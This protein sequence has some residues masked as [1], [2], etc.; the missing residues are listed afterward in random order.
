MV[1]KKKGFLLF[2]LAVVL[3]IIFLLAGFGFA[4]SGV[5]RRMAVR[6]DVFKIAAILRYEW[7]R[8]CACQKQ[9]TVSIDLKKN[10]LRDEQH[11]Y[12]LSSDVVFGVLAS[13]HGP[14][15]RPVH[16]LTTPSSFPDNKI[17]FFP[18]RDGHCWSSL[19]SRLQS[20]NPVCNND[21]ASQYILCTCL[22]I[23]CK[24]MDFGIRSY[25]LD[26]LMV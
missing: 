19:Y 1:A 8:A 12:S 18:R 2:E 20:F 10:C 15:S 21:S 7:I 11:T 17:I 3:A 26:I 6:A 24:E 16:A 14:P 5:V 4:L 22:C 25:F 9:I 23:S 13:A